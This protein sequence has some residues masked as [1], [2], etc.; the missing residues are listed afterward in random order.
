MTIWPDDKVEKSD[1]AFD[2]LVSPEL[3]LSDELVLQSLE[4][5]SLELSLTG[6]THNNLYPKNIRKVF[7]ICN[8]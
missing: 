7:N 1:S 5:S 2:E 3:S 6:R 8:Q 4:L